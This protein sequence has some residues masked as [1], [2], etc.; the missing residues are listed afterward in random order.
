MLQCLIWHRPSPDKSTCFTTPDHLRY[1]Q[2]Q[3]ALILFSPPLL[4]VMALLSVLT[5]VLAVVLCLVIGFM[6]VK[7]RDTET[8][9]TSPGTTKGSSKVDSRPWADQD[10][11]DDTVISARE[12]GQT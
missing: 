7:T 4:A 1:T 6:L 11:Q 5:P 12:E 10:L 9:S 2:A 8:S 3:V